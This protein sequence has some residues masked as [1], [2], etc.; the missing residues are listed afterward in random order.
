MPG[1]V[2]A[3]F[4]FEDQRPVDGA[5]ALLD[6]RLNGL[7]NK[8]LLAGSATG[9]LG[10]YILVSNNGKLQAQWILFVG[11]GSLQNLAP[12]TYGGL[13]GSV[14]DDCRRAGFSK[15]SLCLTTPTGAALDWVE[16]L[17]GELALVV[18]DMEIVLTLQESVGT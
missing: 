18:G 5:S 10:E 3:G 13:V 6:W 11:G 12:F 7:L 1:E 15:V 16:Q 2:V 14:I 17:A 9:R 8:L 4:F